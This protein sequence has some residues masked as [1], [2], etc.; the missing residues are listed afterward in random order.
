MD[1][2]LLNCY[3]ISKKTTK[4]MRGGGGPDRRIIIFDKDIEK[5]NT[6]YEYTD[7]EDGCSRKF[8]KK[9]TGQKIKNGENKGKSQPIRLEDY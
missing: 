7:N 5:M 8:L 3:L 1:S 9:Y 6:L 2:K 4:R